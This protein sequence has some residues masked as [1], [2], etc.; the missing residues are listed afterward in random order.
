MRER[1]CKNVDLFLLR[2]IPILKS[3]LGPVRLVNTGTIKLKSN[4]NIF[5]I[6]LTTS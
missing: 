3:D 2:Q 1:G 4:E 6:F 5:Y